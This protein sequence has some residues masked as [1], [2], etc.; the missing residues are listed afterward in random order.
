MQPVET[1]F[2]ASPQPTQPVSIHCNGQAGSRIRLTATK[3]GDDPR[4]PK[5]NYEL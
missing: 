1:R 2:I 4:H 5:N 3:D